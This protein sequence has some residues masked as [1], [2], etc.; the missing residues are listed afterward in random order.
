MCWMV[1]EQLNGS[2]SKEHDS[3]R[4]SEWGPEAAGVMAQA[5]RD[6]PIMNGGK[7]GMTMG[8]L[9][10]KTDKDLISKVVLEEKVYK[11]W[12]GGRTVLLGDGR[13]EWLMIYTQKRR[14]RN[15]KILPNIFICLCFC[16][17]I[18]IGF[19]SACHKVS[20]QSR[21]R[22]QNRNAMIWYRSRY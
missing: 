9:I 12:S 16:A 3:S 14:A 11:T 21:S 10:D 15:M 4:S 7:P 22:D 17:T 6:F 19:E 8:H 18:F 20:H 5:V 13:N 1:V 2:L